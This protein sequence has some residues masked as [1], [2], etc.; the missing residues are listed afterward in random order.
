MNRCTLHGYAVS[1]NPL[2]DRYVLD[3]RVQL[4]LAEKVASQWAMVRG[5]SSSL[6][7]NTGA[8]DGL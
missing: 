2:R 4:P 3:T 7:C 6:R 8:S 5:L 1:I